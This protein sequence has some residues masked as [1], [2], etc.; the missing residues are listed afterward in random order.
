MAYQPQS[1][2]PAATQ[3]SDAAARAVCASQNASTT[4]PYKQLHLGSDTRTR[5]VWQK[6]P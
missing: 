6:T 5:P 4:I 2:T 3:V 1:S